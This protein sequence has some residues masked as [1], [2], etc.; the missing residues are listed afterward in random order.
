[1]RADLLVVDGK[2]L[3]VEAYAYRAGATIKHCRP[4][5][6]LGSP[7]LWTGLNLVDQL[8]RSRSNLMNAGADDGLDCVFRGSHDRIFVG[9]ICFACNV[10][11]AEPHQPLNTIGNQYRD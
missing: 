1:M 10:R 11:Q 6:R 9:C 7:E 2:P 8:L 5:Q 4:Y 3:A